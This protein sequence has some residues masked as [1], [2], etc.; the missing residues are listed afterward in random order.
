MMQFA[1]AAAGACKAGL[2][3]SSCRAQIGAARAPLIEMGAAKKWSSCSAL[4]DPLFCNT[5]HQSR[6]PAH[7][8]SPYPS[9][10]SDSRAYQ[11]CGFSVEPI[12][13]P[14]DTTIHHTRTLHSHFASSIIAAPQQLCG[15]VEI[16]PPGSLYSSD[17]QF[18]IFDFTF[19]PIIVSGA[20][21]EGL[22]WTIQSTDRVQHNLNLGIL[23]FPKV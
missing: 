10:S 14:D 22:L 1:P 23:N 7:P 16:N 21:F 15:F 20:N 8:H 11:F 2:L 13:W 4:I 17:L 12:D 19:A 5:R 6:P 9:A 3:V 18:T